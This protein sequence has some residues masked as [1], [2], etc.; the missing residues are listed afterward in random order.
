MS[1]VNSGSSRIVKPLLAALLISASLVACS[2][3]DDDKDMVEGPDTGP[4]MPVIGTGTLD[5]LIAQG[6]DGTPVNDGLDQ[7]EADLLTRFGSEDGMPFPVGD[8]D[9]VQTLLAN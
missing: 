3:N 7:V 1:S 2:S 6:E 4:D 9:T 8:T 5:Q